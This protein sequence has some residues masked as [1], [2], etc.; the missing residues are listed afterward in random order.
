MLRRLGTCPRVISKTMKMRMREICSRKTTTTTIQ[1][2]L[3]TFVVWYRTTV[4][5][6]D[7]M[8]QERVSVLVRSRSRD[9][10]ET[11]V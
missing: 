6:A 3:L 7:K 2:H 10:E 8:S 1:M 9:D 11:M 5:E 4:G